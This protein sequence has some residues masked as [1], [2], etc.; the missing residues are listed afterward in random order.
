MKPPKSERAAWLA[1]N[2][3]LIIAA[4]IIAY[5][6]SGCMTYK[7]AVRKFAHVATDSVPMTTLVPVVIR[8]TIWMP[9]D[10][11]TI[12]VKT[13][14]TDFLKTVTGKRT[15]LTF[16]RNRGITTLTAE[17]KPDTII[18]KLTKTVT[19]RTK[20]PPV[21]TFGVAPWY[22]TAFYISLALLLAMAL[23]YLFIYHF[24]INIARR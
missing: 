16:A 15:K 17:A 19:I 7:Q 23:A 22:K 12:S 14:T 1:T 11:V 10:T 4:L 21:A 24:K 5:C 18:R 9:G 20:C 8:D 13:D 6:L 2:A 3:L